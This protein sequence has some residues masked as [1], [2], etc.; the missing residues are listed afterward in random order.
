MTV[1]DPRFHAFDGML[2]Q[3]RCS[4]TESPLFTSSCIA[5]LCC[6]FSVAMQPTT[7]RVVLQRT[8]KTRE[9]GNGKERFNGHGP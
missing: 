9:G 6:N 4:H 2:L 5:I 1:A 7:F 8:T 3:D